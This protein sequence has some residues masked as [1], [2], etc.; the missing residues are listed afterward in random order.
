MIILI[1]CTNKSELDNI[2]KK[3]SDLKTFVDSL[4]TTSL[5]YTKCEECNLS[6]LEGEKIIGFT[7]RYPPK[8][9][10]DRKEINIGF[11]EYDTYAIFDSKTDKRRIGI[12]YICYFNQEQKEKFIDFSSYYSNR[13]THGKRSYRMEY[14][15]NTIIINIENPER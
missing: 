4:K 14:I 7:D 8:G 13:I 5:I 6:G 10:Y 3:N 15:N 9:H 11:F 1:A 2:V 12:M